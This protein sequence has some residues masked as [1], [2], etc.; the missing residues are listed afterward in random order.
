MDKQ[1]Q[2]VLQNNHTFLLN[3]VQYEDVCDHL[4][5]CRILSFDKHEEINSEKSNK[6]KVCVIYD[7]AK[8]TVY[9]YSSTLTFQQFLVYISLV[10]CYRFV[11]C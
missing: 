10:L 8:Y 7:K 3:N 9:N 1:H 11:F 4:I 2:T 5:E 6:A